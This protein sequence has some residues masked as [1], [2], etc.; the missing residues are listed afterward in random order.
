VVEAAGHAEGARPVLPS[1]ALLLL[2]I[3]ARYAIAASGVGWFQR[4][5]PPGA[6]SG[7][8][9]PLHVTLGGDGQPTVKLLGWELLPDSQVKPG[10]KLRVRLYWQTQSRMSQSL[11]SFVH[12][13]TPALRRSWAVVQ[14]DN[15]GR[16]PTSRW[17]PAL[18]VVDD[19]VLRLP[20]DLP[21]VTYTLAA[22]LVDENG[23]RLKVPD[24]DDGLVM[25]REIA[26]APLQ[27]G[28]WQ[29]LRPSVAA[30]A[31]FGTNLKLQGYDLRLH[32][33]NLQPSGADLRLYWQVLPSAGKGAK[34]SDLFTFIHLVDAENKIIAQFDG[35]PL[36]GLCPTS[37]WS[38]GALII[39]RHE[40]RWPQNLPGAAL[41][42]ADGYRILVGL[43]DPNSLTRAAV[44]P[45]DGAGD[46]FSTDNALVIPLSFASADDST[47][48]GQP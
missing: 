20:L 36:E 18:Y 13:V 22:G 9:V 29:P 41:Y 27:A 24:N 40:L 15:P 25:L 16:V 6:V 3:G 1:L 14:N 17:S 45:E 7:A 35:P 2:L 26:L 5:S 38:P 44:S 31:T 4:T 43:Y 23:L 47:S 10:G 32:A 42:L 33:G 12:L 28:S 19:L 30:L 8:E 39:D 34:R 48:N 37:Q 21:P 11:K 46:H